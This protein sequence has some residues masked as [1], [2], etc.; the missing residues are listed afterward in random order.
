MEL[1][2]LDDLMKN[3]TTLGEIEESLTKLNQK[4]D[5]IREKIRNWLILHG[6]NEY[7]TFDSGGDKLWRLTL[8]GASRKSAN[9]EM[10][11]QLLSQE[12]FNDVVSISEYDVLK[13]Q[14]VKSRSKKKSAPKANR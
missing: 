14:P 8:K 11:E 5:I 7:E 6:I 2:Y 10:L 4:K 1:Q 13:I 3:L 9:I 12:D